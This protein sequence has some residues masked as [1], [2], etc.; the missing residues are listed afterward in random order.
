MKA[1]KEWK[2]MAR[3]S[4]T[5]QTFNWKTST[6]SFQI[7]N[8]FLPRIFMQLPSN[9]WMRIQ[10]ERKFHLPRLNIHCNAAYEQ[11][12]FH[13]V[14]QPVSS[15]DYP[16][17]NSSWQVAMQLQTFSACLRLSETD[18]LLVWPKRK[19]IFFLSVRW[20]RHY[21][22]QTYKLR[23]QLYRKRELSLTHETLLTKTRR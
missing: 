16:S 13:V 11:N 6:I 23:L 3:T 8:R 18:L 10:T 21:K 15:S 19:L 17:K 20:K 22:L 4:G 9:S 7:R 12:C 1:K 2:R 5:S 14:F